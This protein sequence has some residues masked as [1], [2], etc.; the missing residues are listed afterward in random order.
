M[1]FLA[2]VVEEIG[3]WMVRALEHSFLGVHLEMAPL[4]TWM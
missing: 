4:L 1:H 3:M 2:I